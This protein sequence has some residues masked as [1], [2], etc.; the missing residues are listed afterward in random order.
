M[1]ATAI[2]MIVVLMIGSIFTQASSAWDAGYGRAG[3]GAA[4]RS[5]AGALSR[6][7]S[8]V[9][10]MRALFPNESDPVKISGSSLEFV[11]IKPNDGHRDEANADREFVWI[12]Y[13]FGTSV[14]REE[15]SLQRNSSGRWTKGSSSRSFLYRNGN[16]D[17]SNGTGFDASFSIE[18]V[19]AKGSSFDGRPYNAVDVGEVAWS[20]GGD[21]PVGVKLRMTLRPSGAF[22]SLRVYSTGRDGI[23]D[24]ESK[25]KDDIVAL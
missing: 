1:V 12:R 21:A 23:K 7:L 18:P 6:D 8:S 9:V 22:S 16:G 25:T 2:L 4:L 3:G 19:E 14:Q 13:S 15:A 5:V 24:S 17:S 11:A 20:D 10:D